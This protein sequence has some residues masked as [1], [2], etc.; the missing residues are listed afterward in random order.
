MLSRVGR[1][2]D[3][4]TGRQTADHAVESV[5][6]EGGDFFDAAQAYGDALG[7]AAIFR[8]RQLNADT[9]GSLPVRIVSSGDTP[10]DPN[11]DQDWGDLLSEAVLSMQDAGF[12]ALYLEDRRFL[13]VLDHRQV[14]ASFPDTGMAATPSGR[15]RPTWR[16]NTTTMRTRGIAAEL[17]PVTMNATRQT[18]SGVGWMQSRR[19]QGVLAAQ[20]YVEDYFRNQARPG[21]ILRVPGTYTQEETDKLLER[22]QAAQTMRRPAVISQSMEWKDTAFSPSDSQWVETHRMSTGDVALL[23]GLPG[24]LL[25]YNTPGASLTYANL[26]DLHEQTWRTTWNPYY[27]RRLTRQI[28]RAIR[29][30]I[31]LDPEGLFLASLT[32]RA[33]A[34]MQLVQAGYDPDSV[35]DRVGLDG[36][37]HTGEIPTTLREVTP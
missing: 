10:P 23:A 7:V 37:R 21:G 25:D 3:F 6:L 19:I 8:A 30:E 24:T 1:I 12:A 16:W 22:W 17:F 4:L 32:S 29:T 20:A 36:L 34:A 26:G 33:T 18:P 11:P 9:I 35:S 14:S 15:L 28:S 5:I 31:R 2:T 27:V 13:Y